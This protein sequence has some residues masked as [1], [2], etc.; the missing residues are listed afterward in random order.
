VVGTRRQTGAVAIDNS[1][2]VFLGYVI[3]APERDWNDCAGVD[4]KGKTVIMLVNDPG[5]ATQYPDI[6]NGNATTYYGHWDYK[7]A[8]A[9]RQGASAAIIIH[10]T[11]PAAY[12]WASVENSWTGHQFDR[13]MVD[14][15]EMLLDIQGCI[16]QEK[17]W[18]LFAQVDLDL[19][20]LYELAKTPGFT[21]ITV[22]LKA[23]ID[24]ETSTKQILSQNVVAMLPGREAL[25]EYFIYMAHW[26]I[27]AR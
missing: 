24:L 4:V 7:Y 1:D 25:Q 8:E 26:V 20:Q 22:T 23:A 15:D 9:A 21:A 11:K 2:V 10:D 13:V 3:N 27:W 17:A 16:Q 5:F 12:P 14:A 19:E 18:E 6:Y